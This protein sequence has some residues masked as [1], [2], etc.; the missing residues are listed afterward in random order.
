MWI[1]LFEFVTL[2]SFNI[3]SLCEFNWFRRKSKPSWVKLF[4]S[5]TDISILN[6]IQ[7]FPHQHYPTEE[8]LLVLEKFV[9]LNYVPKRCNFIRLNE[10]RWH[11]IQEEFIRARVLTSNYR[12]FFPARLTIVFCKQIYGPKRKSPSLTT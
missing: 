12:R 11:V 8:E 7:K 6:A 1:R 2:I 9:S 5:I 4:L 3:S 10:A